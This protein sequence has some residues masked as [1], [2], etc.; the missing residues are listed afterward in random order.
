M[1]RLGLVLAALIL[2]AGCGTHQ[3]DV[4]VLSSPSDQIVWE[5]AQKASARKDWVSARQYLKRIVDAFPQSPRQ[6]DARI[7]L[8]DSYLEDGGTA[9]Y[10]LAAAAYREFLT[11][12]PRH[13]KAD[14]AQF[15]AGEC[16]FK[17]KNSPD[18]DQTSTQQALEEYQRLLDVYPDSARVEETRER[19][20]QCRQ[21]LARSHHLVAQFYQRARR[22]WRSAIFRYEIV[23]AE[24][25]D[26]ERTDE[27]LLR[28]AQC[29]ATAG[30]YAEALPHLGRLEKEFPESAFAARAR[31]L[32]AGFPASAPQPP[33]ATSQTPAS[34]G[35]PAGQPPPP[36]E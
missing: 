20:R 25:P 21:T 1:R 11:L 15:R 29:L 35:L 9:N 18:R 34:G 31:E 30:R 32:R 4:A 33:A 26:Y 3:V 8:A 23:L 16:Y 24:Y 28:L 36:S 5:A 22:A 2:T 6:P 10:V 27:V 19:I 17:Q 12:F 7:A 14:Y 13:P